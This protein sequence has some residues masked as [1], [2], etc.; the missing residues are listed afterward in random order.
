MK[1][2]IVMCAIVGMM[3]L[4]GCASDP[5]PTVAATSTPVAVATDTPVAATPTPTPTLEPTPIPGA[6][7]IVL[8]PS[9][10]ATLYDR[11]ALA[12]ANGGGSSLF[13]GTTNGG[14]SRRALVR[15]DIGSAISAGSTVASVR[16]VMSVDRTRGEADESTLHLLTASWGEGTADSETAGGGSGTAP[17]DGSATWE[18]RSFPDVAWDR[19]GGDYERE[20]HAT[21]T[22]QPP[23]RTQVVEVTW[24]ST[25]EMVDDVQR[26]LV[27][28][29]SNFGWMIL[30][31]EGPNQTAKRVASRENTDS[32]LQPRLI[33]EYV[34]VSG[35][36]S[37]DVMPSQDT[38]IYDD[39]TLA[40]G[41][42]EWVF[43]GV[44]LQ[45]AIRRALMAFDLSGAV[46]AGSTVDSATLTLMVS[47]SSTDEQPISLYELLAA[48]SAGASDAETNEGKGALALAGDATWDS[49][50]LGGTWA[51]AGGDHGQTP[52]GTSSVADSG[53]TSTWELGALVQ[54]WVDEPASNHGVLLIGNEEAEH[55]AKRFDALEN[56]SGFPVPHPPILT[57]HYTP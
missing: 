4:A 19:S 36:Q 51:T 46:P 17:D 8:T 57:I 31:N 24:G 7:A 39:A 43:A 42:G 54:R 29:A 38:T 12:A 3:A 22:V 13:F 18:H 30:G 27:N 2:Y 45:G 47:R 32:A 9:A 16:L 14:E 1:P 23:P 21:I 33:V 34:P 37:V 48:W 5:T 26:W 50:G 11:G 20:P 55:T 40:N 6:T 49:T 41:A 35:P 53:T 25:V 52:L 15:F 56:I 10:D 44:T 28:P